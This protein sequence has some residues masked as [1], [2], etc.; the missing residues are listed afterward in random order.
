[1]LT[2]EQQELIAR[3][4]AREKEAVKDLGEVIG[5]GAMMQLAQECWRDADI[6]R[7]FPP[8]MEHTC[9]PAAAETVPC[10]CREDNREDLSSC[11]WCC[12]CGWLT[13]KVKALQAAEKSLSLIHI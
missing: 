3:T 1:M 10:G 7:G 5:Y 11:D 6:A 12:G 2:R 8:G 4:L 13:K 9:G